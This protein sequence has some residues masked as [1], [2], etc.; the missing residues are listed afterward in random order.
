MRK[1]AS[2]VLIAAVFAAFA[3]TALTCVIAAVSI[4]HRAIADLTMKGGSTGPLIVATINVKGGNAS[5]GQV[6]ALIEQSGADSWRFPKRARNIGP[7]WRRRSATATRGRAC[8]S[9]IRR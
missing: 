6:A 4:A 1:R 2:R 9:R 3:V 8:R 7:H 5:V